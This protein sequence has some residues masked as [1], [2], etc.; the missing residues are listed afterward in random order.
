MR[1]ICT[2]L[3]LAVLALGHHAAHAQNAGDVRELQGSASVTRGDAAAAA[4]LARGAAVQR[5]DIVETADNG[6]VLIGF[7]DGTALT[8]GPGAEVVID[9]F[10]YNPNGGANSAALRVAAGA[11]RL[12]SGAIERAG[13][14][15]AVTVTTA[16]GT[17]GIRGTDFFVEMDGD[18]L[19]VALF[20][21]QDVVVRNANGTTVLRPGEGTDIWGDKAP[22]Q[23]VTW[24]YDRVNR[25][26]GL[27][28]VA[29]VDKRPLPYARSVAPAETLGDALSGGKFKIDGRLR[30]EFVDHASQPQTAY[31][32]TG[33]LRAGYETL[34][35][36]GL[37]AG[38]EG[39][40]THHL[41][42]RRSDGAVNVPALPV[43]ADP[44]SEVLNQ[45]YAG[46]TLP[47]ADGMPAARLVVGRQRIAYDNERWVGPGSFRQNDQTLDAAAVEARALPELSLRY[48]YV[49]R[50]NRILGNNPNGAWD[51]DSHF[52]G[53]STTVVPF[54]VTTAY[55]YL[56]DLKPVPQFSSA[57]YGVRYDG[58]YENGP[59]AFGLEAEVARQT[60]YAA[61][62]RNYA[63]TYALIRPSLR[64][65]DSTLYAGWENLG[66]DG[67]SAVQAPLATLHRHNGWADMFLVTPPNGLRDL[68]VRFFQELPDLGPMKTPKL[69]VR[70]HD[71]AAVRGGAH[72]GTEFDV[73]LNATIFSR[74]TMGV[75]FASYNADAFDSDTKKLW[76]YLEFQY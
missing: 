28:T 39:E 52:A 5:N 2:G 58:L 17:I 48:A 70:F 8:L 24:G 67:V 76:L 64:W 72:Y 55:A 6:K 9:E 73:D 14:P 57:T 7:V 41:A 27:V 68:H 32:L 49:D 59:F 11:M 65:N 50:V 54:G 66:G 71:F 34:A 26:L 19:S 13:G 22:S 43:I 16:V 15:Q 30:Y 74:V 20:S 23:A 46:W 10:V 61:N 63:L 29:G 18:H 69:D 37:F 75:R 1:K 60:D 31:A 44:D 38:I 42:A 4:A 25:A 40:V 53:A 33:R 62:P 3:A 56:L 35:W 45:L 21:G 36:N 12:V 47:G 51:S